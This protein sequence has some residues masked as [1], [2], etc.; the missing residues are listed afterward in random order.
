METNKRELL[1]YVFKT[2]AEKSFWRFISK[3]KM[4]LTSSGAHT[5]F[6]LICLDALI[7]KWESFHRIKGHLKLWASCV[8]LFLPNW[9][10][11][12]RWGG[13]KNQRKKELQCN[14]EH[15]SYLWVVSIS[16]QTVLFYKSPFWEFIGWCPF[17]CWLFFFPWQMT[18]LSHTVDFLVPAQ[19]WQCD[20]L[21]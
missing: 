1:F 4:Q 15:R 2:V 16:F 11:P 7:F 6:S 13:K 8:A 9:F 18:I 17:C 14:A 10:S 12:C 5:Y 21:F 3:S 19:S 20:I